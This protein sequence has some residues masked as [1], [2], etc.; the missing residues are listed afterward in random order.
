MLYTTLPPGRNRMLEYSRSLE[1]RRERN[2]IRRYTSSINISPIRQPRR[3]RE[4]FFN[5]E[6]NLDYNNLS[7]LEDVKIGL[8]NKKILDNSNVEIN[9]KKEE[10]CIICQDDLQIDDIL[11]TIKCNHSFHLNCIDKWFVENKKCPMC[12]YEL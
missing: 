11:R 4:N 8:I 12:N 5:L 6:Y 2:N 7:T 10:I 3:I 9:L 1:L